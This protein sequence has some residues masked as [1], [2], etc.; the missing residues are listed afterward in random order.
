MKGVVEGCCCPGFEK[1]K[2]AQICASQMYIYYSD[3]NID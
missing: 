1:S 2:D 3:F